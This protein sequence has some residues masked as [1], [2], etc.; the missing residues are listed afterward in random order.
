MPL[1]QARGGRRRLPGRGAA[2]K[3]AG[4]LPAAVARMRRPAPD[5]APAR[6]RLSGRCSWALLCKR[7]PLCAGRAAVL[8]ARAGHPH[9]RD[10]LRGPPAIPRRRTQ[11]LPAARPAPAPR[12]TADAARSAPAARRPASPRRPAGGSHAAARSSAKAAM[13]VN[14]GSRLMKMLQRL[15]PSRCTPSIHRKDS[16]TDEKMPAYRISGTVFTSSAAWAAGTLR[17]SGSM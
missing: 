1:A 5:C 12:R 16:S 17:N 2:D 4:A 7:A 15:G 10:A 8:N 14:S 6:W 3:A 11:A 13:A 9:A